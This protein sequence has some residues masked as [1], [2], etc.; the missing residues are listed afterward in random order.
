MKSL[1]SRAVG[2]MTALSL[3]I[4]PVLSNTARRISS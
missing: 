1:L 2:T 4:V 3:G